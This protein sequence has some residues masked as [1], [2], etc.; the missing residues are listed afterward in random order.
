MEPE[1]LRALICEKP[2]TYV[3]LRQV[4][5]KYNYVIKLFWLPLQV[6]DGLNP[7]T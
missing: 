1:S 7:S 6:A 3:L 4:C 2:L 5:I